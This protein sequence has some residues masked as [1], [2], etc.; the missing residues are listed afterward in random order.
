M[1][2]L[3]LILFFPV[4]HG[5]TTEEE[6]LYNR[7]IVVELTAL[8]F[9]QSSLTYNA[10]S[11]QSL[12]TKISSIS[13]RL[14]NEKSGEFEYI[15]VNHDGEDLTDDF[16]LGNDLSYREYLDMAKEIKDKGYLVV[17]RDR[18]R[19]TTIEKEIKALFRNERY[20]YPE[21]EMKDILEDNKEAYKNKD[22]EAINLYLMKQGILVSMKRQNQ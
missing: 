12:A 8:P 18:Y 22:Y 9:H 5:C 15:I 2:L 17:D 16:P 14:R 4:L 13:H 10:E 21:N 6:T 1:A 19:V 11:E 3:A 7:K 20:V